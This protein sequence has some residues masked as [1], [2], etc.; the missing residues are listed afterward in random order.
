MMKE[1]EQDGL[2][3]ASILSGNRN[4]EAR[5]QQLIKANFLAS[6]PLVIAYS[7]AGTVQINLDEQPIQVTPNGKPVYLKD[8]WPSK[9]E[10]QQIID[11]FVAASLFEENYKTIFQ[12]ERWQAIPSQ[13]S[14]H[15]NWDEQ[16]TY[17]QPSPFFS[18]EKSQ[19]L[20]GLMPLLV[21]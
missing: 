10:I 11:E 9:E 12:N 14:I 20:Q 7:L 3:A 16:S 13:Q 5:V 15:F 1:I 4:F 2:V 21:L 18:R 6:P 17:I 8:I 19:T